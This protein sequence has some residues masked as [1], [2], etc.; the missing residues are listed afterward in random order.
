MLRYNSIIL[1]PYFLIRNI[2]F[3]NEW[4]SLLGM[5]F[6]NVSEWVQNYYRLNYALPEITDANNIISNVLISNGLVG[7][8][9][10]FFACTHYAGFNLNKVFIS[11]MML[12][13]LSLFSGYAFGSF[14]VLTLLLTRIY[15][16]LVINDD[17]SIKH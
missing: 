10:Y 12:V 14:A 13:I 16:L 3:G 9:C 17:N 15:I 8:I 2:S 6:G 11:I 7:L 1:G 5:G 4:V